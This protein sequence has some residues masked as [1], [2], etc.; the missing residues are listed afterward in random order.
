MSSLPGLNLNS[1]AR[2]F[3]R[4]ERRLCEPQGASRGF[5]CFGNA[6]QRDGCIAGPNMRNTA[7]SAFRP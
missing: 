2:Y 1:P 7:I 6:A 5:R 4:S 3:R